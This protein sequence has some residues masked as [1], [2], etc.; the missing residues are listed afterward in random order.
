MCILLYVKLICVWE[1]SIGFTIYV[2]LCVIW[3]S[4][5]PQIGGGGTCAEGICAFCYM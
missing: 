1:W 3:C 5:I 2:H 4:G